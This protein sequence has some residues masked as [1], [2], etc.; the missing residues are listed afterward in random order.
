MTVKSVVTMLHTGGAEG[1][2]LFQNSTHLLFNFT[3]PWMFLKISPRSTSLS[4]M[5]HFIQNVSSAS[6]KSTCS[7][8]SGSLWFLTYATTLAAND[9]YVSYRFVSCMCVVTV[10]TVSLG[11][12]LSSISVRNGSSCMCS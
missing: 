6:T 1:V 2:E 9:A 3:L 4:V 8:S 7:I 5:L 12:G 10:T 11:C